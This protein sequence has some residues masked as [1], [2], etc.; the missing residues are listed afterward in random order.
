MRKLFISIPMTGRSDDVVWKEMHIW[1]KKIE[2]HYGEKFELIDNLHKEGEMNSVQMLGDSIDLM[3]KA[4]LIFFVPGWEN[5]KGCRIEYFVT[6]EYEM[7]S[8]TIPASERELI[9]GYYV[10][11]DEIWK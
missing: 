10:E 6:Q 3:G 2:K 11:E 4:D 9:K 8:Q 7:V 1:K 5:S